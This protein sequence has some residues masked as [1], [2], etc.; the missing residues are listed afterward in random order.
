[1]GRKVGSFTNPNT[2]E[3]DWLEV[4]TVKILKLSPVSITRFKD[5]EN[6]R[7]LVEFELG[8][9]DVLKVITLTATYD[10]N[11]KIYK[12]E[13]QHIDELEF[14]EKLA[15]AVYADEVIDTS[16]FISKLKE[17]ALNDLKAKLLMDGILVDQVD[18]KGAGYVISQDKKI[19]TIDELKINIESPNS[20]EVELKNCVGP[21]LLSNLAET[22]IVFYSLGYK[23]KIMNFE[24]ENEEDGKLKNFVLS[25]S[26]IDFEEVEEQESFKAYD[27]SDLDNDEIVDQFVIDRQEKLDNIYDDTESV[28]EDRFVDIF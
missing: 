12:S 3:E 20:A 7:S 19:L 17:E 4:N 23:F 21:A 24:I 16:D 2:G 9:I 14:A 15:N 22:E 26:D 1:M 8:N 5:E 25:T 10:C 18:L 27:L 11:G 28:L 13:A 6:F